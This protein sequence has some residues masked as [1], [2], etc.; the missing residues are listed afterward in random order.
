MKAHITQVF[1]LSQKEEEL[2]FFDANLAYDSPLFIDPFL[3]KRSPIA[4]ERD[5]FKRFGSFFEY[6]Y[7]NSLK[8]NGDLEASKLLNFL[9]F[10]EPKEICLGYTEKSNQGSGPGS[11][12]ASSLLHFFL[13]S[14]AKRI[15]F[16]KEMYPD[17]E[18]NPAI[19]SFFAEHLGPDGVSDIAANLIMDYLIEYTQ[20]HCK[21]LGIK[22]KV[23]PV[24]QTFDFSEMEWTNGLH[25][26]LP[27][28][29]FRPGEPIIFVPKRLVRATELV[30]N[31]KNKI[32]GI[33]RNDPLLKDRFFLLLSK[34]M[35]EIKIEEINRLL[36]SEESLFK[37]YFLVLE[38]EGITPYDFQKDILSFLA[39]K[40]YDNYFDK[41][42]IDEDLK[43]CDS[44]VKHTQALVE[45]FKKEMELRDGWKDMWKVS[46]G[47]NKPLSEIVFGRKF[48]A[49]GYAY[50][51]HLKDVTFDAEIGTGGGFLD[52]RVI[53]K[54]C[55]IAIE[56]KLLC[57][58]SYAG[59]PPLRAYIHGIKRQLPRYCLICEASHAMYITGQHYREQGGKKPKNHDSRM[60]DVRVLV[61]EV[62]KDIRNNLSCFDS[63]VYENI[64]L[65]PRASPSK[66]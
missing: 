35:N 5:L 57:N 10:H 53:Y 49:M 14:A 16:K 29:P 36:L 27:E 62:E 64:D 17:G 54:K 18:F 11:T 13:T 40:H 26:N 28:N 59:K 23:L 24:Q 20:D 30:Q 44:L 43:S 55:R 41:S 6:V 4:G 50:F 60:K 45:E 8:V 31:G 58:N 46:K 34:K 25:T 12:L 38:K 21:N 3:L 2:D 37:K 19:L 63:L 51:K 48:R 66:I 61:P 33:L 39:I 9:N 32:V 65:S 1:N 52:F 15:I 42:K 56:L 7:N 47:K 22:M